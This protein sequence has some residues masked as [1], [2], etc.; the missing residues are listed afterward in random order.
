MTKIMFL[1]LRNPIKLLIHLLDYH[2][3]MK[4]G[5]GLKNRRLEK[6]IDRMEFEQM[7]KK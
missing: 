7:K 5:A 4:R 2:I 3:K 1:K 6:Y